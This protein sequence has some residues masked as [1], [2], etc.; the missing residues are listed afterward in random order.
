MGFAVN[1][2]SLRLINTRLLN[3]WPNADANVHLKVY[4]SELVDPRNQGFGTDRPTYEIYDSTI[5]LTAVTNGGWM[6]LENVNVVQYLQVNGAAS[7]IWG[8]NVQR[9]GGG[10]PQV[11]QE[12]GG[13]YIQLSKPGIPW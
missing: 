6:Y 5:S 3:A 11:S 1:N 10:S 2:S 12:A 13:R 8:Y 4:D 7:T 9:A